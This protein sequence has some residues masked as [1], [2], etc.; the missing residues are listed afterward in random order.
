[1]PLTIPGGDDVA[2][3]ADWAELRILTVDGD[4]LSIARLN[5]LLR[6]EGGDAAEEEFALEAIDEEDDEHT[7]LELELVDEGRGERDMRIEQLLDEVELRFRL[8]PKLYPFEATDER[9]IRRDPAGGESYRFLLTISSKEAAFRGD[10]RT[11]EIEAAFDRV[12]LEALRRYLGREANGLRFAKNAHVAEDNASRPKKFREA[13]EWLRGQ[14]KLGRGL[15]EPPDDELEVHWESDANPAHQ[16]LNTYSDAGVDAVVWWRFGDQ[17]A[18][19]PVLLAQCTVQIEWGEKTKDIPVELWKK[20]ID[21]ETVPPQT[22]LVIPFA[23]SRGLEQWANRTV[24]A[25]VIIDR[26]RLLELLDEL[27]EAELG[28]LIDGDTSAWITA[29]LASL[30]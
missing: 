18:G 15:I 16:P 12:A 20:W 8:G 13:I 2:E 7:E 4:G 9:L 5:E 27:E 17:R 11:H 28:E 30:V 3:L 14:L 29:E 1:M 24:T 21:F 10:R 23:V 25:G 26:L 22:A 19:A 6:G